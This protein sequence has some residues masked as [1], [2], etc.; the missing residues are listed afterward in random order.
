M[1]RRPL[2]IAA[3][4]VLVAAG[5]IAALIP[6]RLTCQ[7]RRHPAGIDCAKVVINFLDEGPSLFVH[8]YRQIPLRIGIIAI[9]AVLATGLLVVYDRQMDSP[10]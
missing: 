5:V 1:S 4:V 6:T 3:V 7:T 2:L 9:G 8:R 10:K